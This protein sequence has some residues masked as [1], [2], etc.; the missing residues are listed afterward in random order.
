MFMFPLIG[1]CG[2]G[3]KSEHDKTGGADVFTLEMNRMGK[4]SV[5]E[6]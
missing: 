3:T 6:V 2:A 1:S 5:D 4:S